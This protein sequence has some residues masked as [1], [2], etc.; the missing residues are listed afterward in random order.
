VEAAA[1]AGASVP[2]AT[3][4]A[5]AQDR[6]AQKALARLERQIDRLRSR[7]DALHA[8]LAAHA[9]DFE[10][11]TGLHQELRAVEAERQSLEEEWLELA[12]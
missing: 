2:P 9:T 7:E 4:S 1:A 8:E 5:S 3:R 10:K 11:V 12:T 6:D